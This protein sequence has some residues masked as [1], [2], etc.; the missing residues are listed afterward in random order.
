MTTAR[1]MRRLLAILSYHKIG[2]AP[3]G[4]WE[5]WTT[6]PWSCSPSRCPVDNEIG[7]THPASSA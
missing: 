3:R 5:P 4:A 1:V 7:G 6:S 2:A